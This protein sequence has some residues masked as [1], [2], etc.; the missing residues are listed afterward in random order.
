MAWEVILVPVMRARR[1]EYYSR[2]ALGGREPVPLTH[3]PSPILTSRTRR[4]RNILSR[5]APSTAGA[6]KRRYSGSVRLHP[7]RAKYALLS[8]AHFA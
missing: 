6:P 3:T 4:G 1:R 2:F 5:G 8:R 7:L